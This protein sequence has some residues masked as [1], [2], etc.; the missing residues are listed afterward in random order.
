MTIEI[1]MHDSHEV[2]PD[3]NI[4]SSRFIVLT[5]LEKVNKFPDHYIRK[6][7]NSELL[8]TKV[9]RERFDL[10]EGEEAVTYKRLV[11]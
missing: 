6:M 2:P 8:K 5:P 1:C 3:R 11:G 9:F 4:T 10:V 7:R